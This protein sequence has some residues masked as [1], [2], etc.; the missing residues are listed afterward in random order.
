MST[1]SKSSSSNDEETKYK[2]KDLEEIVV[3]HRQKETV[4]KKTPRKITF[5]EARGF[6]TRKS[7]VV[8]NLLARKGAEA[9]AR[10]EQN[11][12]AEEDGSDEEDEPP[13][14]PKRPEV[15]EKKDLELYKLELEVWLLDM[16]EYNQAQKAKEA[17]KEPPVVE[18][19]PTRLPVGRV[20]E[21]IGTLQKFTLALAKTMPFSFWW[22]FFAR[23]MAALDLDDATI[24]L[25]L[26]HWVA[27][28]IWK[29]ITIGWSKEQAIDGKFILN[30]LMLYYP[31]PIPQITRR[32]EFKSYIHRKPD[33]LAYS[34]MKEYKFR[35][36]Y[37]MEDCSSTDF[38]MYWLA[39][40]FGPWRYKLN[41]KGVEDYATAL[42][43]CRRWEVAHKNTY[44]YPYIDANG[45]PTVPPRP[46]SV[47]TSRSKQSSLA[48]TSHKM[49][50]TEER[51]CRNWQMKGEC[52]FGS[53][54]RFKHTPK[55]V[56]RQ[57][58]NRITSSPS[59]NRDPHSNC[60]NK[61]CKDDPV[62]EWTKCRK[63][64]FPCSLCKKKDHMKY[65]C[66][67]A[68]CAKCSRSGHS[69]FVCWQTK[70]G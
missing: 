58:T 65:Y 5:G 57:S 4:G 21:K 61:A 6:V 23:E 50:S 25:N 43:H 27:D 62:H 11:E 56:M 9:V 70:K 53:R 1:S 46:N 20:Y 63:P 54:C 8:E 40:L 45:N 17:A 14:R 10:L 35:L 19:A 33:V 51:E 48:T 31:D 15:G 2:S 36:A 28:E 68:V 39:G 67:Q 12:P 7:I 3:A 32:E 16:K 34:S 49:G 66:P 37:P 18:E 69:E 22:Q 38:Y 44:D 30:Q 64:K 13:K 24:L 55:K 60:F 41:T 59:P 29:P 42:N 47:P 52:P 26:K